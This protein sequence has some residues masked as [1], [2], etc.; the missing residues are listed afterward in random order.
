M[1]GARCS[2]REAFMTKDED[3][4]KIETFM[5]EIGHYILVSYC[6]VDG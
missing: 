2:S 1:R 4:S 6:I 5:R 3:G